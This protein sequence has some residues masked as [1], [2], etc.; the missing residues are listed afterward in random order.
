MVLNHLGLQI[1]YSRLARLL[2]AGPSFTPFT[3]LRYLASLRLFILIGEEG[4]VSLFAPYLGL[5]LPVIVGVKTLGWQHWGNEV[6][7][8]AVV[9]IGIDQG[10]GVIY[11]HDP[12]FTQAPIEMSLVEFE[13]GWIKDEGYDAVIGLAPLG[14]QAE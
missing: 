9:V 1:S 13:A 10:R 7:E 4:D 8:H 2:R 5:G 12:Y 3:N 14:E 11:I 6:T